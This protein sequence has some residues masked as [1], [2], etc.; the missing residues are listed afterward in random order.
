MKICRMGETRKPVT[1]LLSIYSHKTETLKWLLGDFIESNE[2]VVNIDFL[3][4]N[5]HLHYTSGNVH[6]NTLKQS[7]FSTCVARFYGEMLHSVI[8]FFKMKC[9][10]NVRG[11]VL[12]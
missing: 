4:N 11:S 7:N 10:N 5:K 12:V 9:R 1:L 3:C 8:K 6:L 2:D